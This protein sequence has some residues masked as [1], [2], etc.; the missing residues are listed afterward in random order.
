MA[1]LVGSL[2]VNAIFFWVHND[3]DTD[4]KQ[5]TGA[6]SICC[7]VKIFLDYHIMTQAD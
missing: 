2:K 4:M 5:T 7:C 6:R 1:T 3:V